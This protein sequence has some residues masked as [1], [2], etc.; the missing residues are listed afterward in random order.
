MV[1]SSVGNEDKGQEIETRKGCGDRKVMRRQEGM[2]NWESNAEGGK[3]GKERKG[4]TRPPPPP[5]APHPPLP[6]P[7]PPRP[8]PPGPHKGRRKGVPKG[9]SHKV[10]Q[11]K[12][13]ELGSQTPLM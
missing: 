7:A 3:E 10:V 13:H 5:P 8:P 2:R 11:T 6:P 1:R 9:R 4:R 12:C